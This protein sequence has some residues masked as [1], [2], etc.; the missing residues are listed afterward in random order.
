M[1]W[2]VLVLALTSY[3]MRGDD[4]KAYEAGCDGYLAKPLGLHVF[5][6]TL[7]RFLPPGLNGP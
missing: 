2:R 4:L 6:K 7:H 1:A 3:A 5:R